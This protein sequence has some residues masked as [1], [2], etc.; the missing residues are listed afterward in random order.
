MSDPAHRRIL[1]TVAGSIHTQS[2]SH[3]N[4]T[5]HEKRNCVTKMPIA[6]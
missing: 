5:N 6:M 1:R 4:A 3:P 2:R